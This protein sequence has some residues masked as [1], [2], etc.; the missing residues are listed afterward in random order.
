MVA[1]RHIRSS[2]RTFVKFNLQSNSHNMKCMSV[3]GWWCTLV[4]LP[5]LIVCYFDTRQF[6]APLLLWTGVAQWMMPSLQCPPW[7]WLLIVNSDESGV[8]PY[9]RTLLN[10][11]ISKSVHFT[12]S[13]SFNTDSMG[14]FD[15]AMVGTS[16]QNKKHLPKIVGKFRNFPEDDW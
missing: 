2:V 10:L 12:K 7:S 3:C 15:N 14:S 11:R 6:Y 13:Y 16:G 4:V 8:K 1:N 9:S 5:M